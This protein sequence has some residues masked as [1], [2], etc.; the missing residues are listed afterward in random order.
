MRLPLVGIVLLALLALN[1]PLLFSYNY[2]PRF[3]PLELPL[4]AGL[5]ALF[6]QD[7]Y[8]LAIGWGKK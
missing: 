8:A 5:G 2:Q 6:V 1:L 7:L 4:L 3:C